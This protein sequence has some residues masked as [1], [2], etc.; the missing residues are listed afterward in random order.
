M[1]RLFIGFILSLSFFYGIPGH[2]AAEK[3]GGS[4]RPMV[5]NPAGY[6]SAG[7]DKTGKDGIERLILSRRGVGDLYKAACT[8]DKIDQWQCLANVVV[9]RNPGRIGINE[10][11]TF[12][13]GDG[14]TASLKTKLVKTETVRQNVKVCPLFSSDKGHGELF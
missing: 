7:S 11:D 10:S 5:E 9:Q 2:S 3:T 1:F 13:F 12:N 4:H 6:R 14:L 8:P